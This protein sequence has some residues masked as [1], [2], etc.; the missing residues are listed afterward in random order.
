MDKVNDIVYRIQRSP[1][2]KIKVVHV[3]RSARYETF[4]SGK[5]MKKPAKEEAEERRTQKTLRI[6]KKY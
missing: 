1:R 4:L 5:Y 2:N 3:K 6:K